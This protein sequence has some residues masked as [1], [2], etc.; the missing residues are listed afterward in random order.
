[1]STQRR[2]GAT[3]KPTGGPVAG[4]GNKTEIMSKII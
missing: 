3:I 1:M 2:I 4:K